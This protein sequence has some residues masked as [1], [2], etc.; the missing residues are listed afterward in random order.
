MFENSVIIPE[1]IPWIMLLV[2]SSGIFVWRFLGVVLSSKIQKDSFFAKW[3]NAI[4]FAMT[5]ALMTR[6]II[7]PTGA[8]AET[9]LIEFFFRMDFLRLF[10]LTFLFF[11][12][13]PIFGLAI[14]VFFFSVGIFIS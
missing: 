14:G 11:P 12:K 10:T 4:A 8:L 2:A 1:I 7:F 6:I 9:E 5:T 13:K 3:I